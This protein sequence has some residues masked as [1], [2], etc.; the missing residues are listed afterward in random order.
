[1][2]RIV[3]RPDVVEVD[4]RGP[5]RRGRAGRQSLGLILILALVAIWMY[6]RGGIE[7]FRRQI[8]FG[9]P[10]PVREPPVEIE[11]APIDPT[12]STFPEQPPER[13]IVTVEPR[14]V[15]TVEPRPVMTVEQQSDV[16]GYSRVA[17]ESVNLR[18]GPGAQYRAIYILPRYWEVAILR[19]L[20]VN[21]DGT[22]WVEV[23]AETN[24]GW[25]KG[26]V[27]QRYLGSC[28]CPTY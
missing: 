7:V 1:M 26:W 14:P 17:A 2:A 12:V 13:P 23:M 15:M 16:M 22:A 20:H 6:Q 21:P 24:Q 8:S 18:V 11:A 25:R 5:Y 10:P 19:Q 27:M 9:A 4:G 28:N 3:G